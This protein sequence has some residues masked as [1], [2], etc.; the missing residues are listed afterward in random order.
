M[1]GVN[2]DSSKR[3]VVRIEPWGGEDL[4]LLERVV[5]DKSMMEH[6]GGAE[7][8]SKIAERQG[9]YEQPGSRQFKIVEQAGGEGVGW[10]GW[11][12]REWRGE[13]VYEIGWSVLAAS[14]G[15]GIAVAA[16]R[17]AIEAARSE[18]GHRFVH[19]FPALPN[20]PSNAICRRLGFLLLGPCELEYPPGHSMRC[21]DWCLDLRAGR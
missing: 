5:G 20:V 17:Q 13:S 3:P 4:W 14:Q 7:S 16:A 1:A 6:L 21:N 2:R 8:P 15:R 11:W 9:R 10:V 19:A 18:A 12:E